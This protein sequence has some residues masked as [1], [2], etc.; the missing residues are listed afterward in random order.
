MMER[1]TNASVNKLNERIYILL[2]IREKKYQMINNRKIINYTK[3]D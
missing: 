2:Y 1:F 3:I